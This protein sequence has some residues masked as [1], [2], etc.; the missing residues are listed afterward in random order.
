MPETHVSRPAPSGKKS[1]LRTSTRFHVDDAVTLVYK[2][3]LL[4]ALGIGRT[5]QARA[6]VNLSEGGILVRTHEPMESGTKVKVRLEIEKFKDV[7]QAEGVVRWCFQNSREQSTYYAGIRF[8]HVPAPVAS[9][10]SKLRGY[11]L[12]PEYRQRTAVRRKR[13]SKAFELSDS[14]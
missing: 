4:S 10:I 8:T 1:D 14:D 13:E 11:F 3:G 5:N 6:T 2:K 9:K 12:S 7:L